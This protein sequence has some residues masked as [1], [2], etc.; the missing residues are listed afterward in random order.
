[1]KQHFI[2]FLKAYCAYDEFMEAFIASNKYFDFDYFIKYTEP[3]LY[4]AGAFTSKESPFTMSE[5]SKLYIE[6][7]RRLKQI[8]HESNT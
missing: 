6:W 2:N 1:M 5:L 7:D 8:N 4:L 3:V